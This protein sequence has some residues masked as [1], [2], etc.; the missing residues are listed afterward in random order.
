MAIGA[1]RQKEIADQLRVAATWV[2]GSRQ[3]ILADL[4]EE[5]DAKA[6]FSADEV[7]AAKKAVE[8]K[9]EPKSK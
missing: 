1:D 7:K 9:A 4:A 3:V 2:S 8:P 6:P 5:L